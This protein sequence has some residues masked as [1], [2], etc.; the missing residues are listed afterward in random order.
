M[1]DGGAAKTLWLVRHGGAAW[2]AEWGISDRFVEELGAAMVRNSSA[3]FMVMRKA[4]V[5]KV[6]T[7]VRQ[8]G[9]TLLCT[10]LSPEPEARL[11][12]DWGQPP[13]LGQGHL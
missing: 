6:A 4:T 3:I 10:P 7:A 8:F 5:D 11:Q 12:A 13:A 9:G 1:P 2:Q